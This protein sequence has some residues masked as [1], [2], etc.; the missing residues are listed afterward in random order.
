MAN[1]FAVAALPF[2]VALDNDRET[3]PGGIG[4]KDNADL[5]P[6]IAGHLPSI[7]LMPSQSAPR[8]PLTRMPTI[9]VQPTRST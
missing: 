6:L 7:T 1:Q 4:G 2:F 5:Y 8:M 9:V 3:N